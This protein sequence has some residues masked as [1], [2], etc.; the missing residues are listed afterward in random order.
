MGQLRSSFSLHALQKEGGQWR[1]AP[2]NAFELSSGAVVASKVAYYRTSGKQAPF[3]LVKHHACQLVS[4]G[5]ETHELL[6]Y[7]TGCLTKHSQ[8]E[9]AKSQLPEKESYCILD[10]PSVIWSE[11][12][13][14]H[15]SFTSAE[16]TNFMTRHS[17]NV[18]MFCNGGFTSSGMEIDKFWALDWNE[19]EDGT[20]STAI[21]L[22]IRLESHSTGQTFMQTNFE[23]HDW[24]LLLVTLQG[25]ADLQIERLPDVSLIPSDYGCIAT[26]IAPHRV[27][28]V[29][30]CGEVVSKCQF[31]VGTS[32]Q[33]VVIFDNGRLVHCVSLQYVPEIIIPMEVMS[34]VTM[35][36]PDPWCKEMLFSLV[37]R[38]LQQ[39][40]RVG[41]W[42]RS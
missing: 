1:F 27:Y 36:L 31:I 22:L 6:R 32:Y 18:Q 28:S 39:K 41:A 17:V 23:T 2:G 15:L 9:I 21:L 4:D 13:T 8:F 33:Q 29:G 24:L 10:G 12:A 25:D 11:R 37:P 3:L 7:D 42:V 5:A 26:C 35:N 20:V 38:L 14:I 30:S 40:K 34:P 19:N 16:E